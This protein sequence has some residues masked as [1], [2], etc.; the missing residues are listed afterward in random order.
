MIAGRDDGRVKAV[1]GYYESGMRS[2]SVS[3][4]TAPWVRR[5]L[6]LLEL[7]ESL[8]SDALEKAD[9]EQSMASPK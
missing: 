9:K 8:T 5:G 6:Q 1:E 4:D 2:A 7:G 3:P